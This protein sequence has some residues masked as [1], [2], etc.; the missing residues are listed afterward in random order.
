MKS[1]KHK[2][3]KI[4]CQFLFLS[5]MGETEK[6]RF[7][8]LSLGPEGS[9]TSFHMRD[10]EM[11]TRPHHNAVKIKVSKELTQGPLAGNHS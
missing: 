2:V 3:N 4:F 1:I 9:S 5:D 6:Y 8:F 7:M 11:T 10:Y